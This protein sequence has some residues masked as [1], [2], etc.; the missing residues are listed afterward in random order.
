[1]TTNDDEVDVSKAPLIEHLIE[2]RSRLIKSLAAFFVMFFI[3][4]FFAKQ[5]YNILLFPYEFAAGPNAVICLQIFTPFEYRRYPRRR[6]SRHGPTDRPASAS[7]FS[8]AASATRSSCGESSPRSPH[9]M[10]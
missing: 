10:S 4:F 1:M 9:S 3:C 5:I 8:T 6:A 2:L 7:T